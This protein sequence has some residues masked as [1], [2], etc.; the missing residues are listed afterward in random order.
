MRLKIGNSNY[1][2]NSH[3]FIII[4]QIIIS[5]EKTFDLENTLNI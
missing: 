2:W 3:N 4:K 1:Y 5:M